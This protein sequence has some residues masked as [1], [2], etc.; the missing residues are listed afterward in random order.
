MTV[1]GLVRAVCLRTLDARARLTE[2]PLVQKAQRVIVLLQ[3]AARRL[4]RRP[5]ADKPPAAPMRWLALRTFLT[6]LARVYVYDV[7][8][9]LLMTV[10][11]PAMFVWLAV[12]YGYGSLDIGLF[13]WGSFAIG[14]LRVSRAWKALSGDRTFAHRYQQAQW[15]WVIRRTYRPHDSSLELFRL[16]RYATSVEQDGG[17]VLVRLLRERPR[18][19]SRTIEVAEERR[20]AGTD[21]KEAALCVE[22]FR[23]SGRERE[24]QALADWERQMERAREERRF[25][26]VLARRDAARRQRRLAEEARRR[27]EAK[28]EADVQRIEAR[29]LVRALRSRRR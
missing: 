15:R 12:V 24:A 7:P 3:L 2:G 27:Q 21:V 25:Q 10:L 23:A 4:R 8:S 6:T 16:G 28:L 14:A 29:G 26:A 19:F 22:E 5:V 17:C 1:D 13:L 11:C 9:A 20:F 18:R